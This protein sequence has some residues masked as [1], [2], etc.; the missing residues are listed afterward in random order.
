M[1]FHVFSL[2]DQST[3]TMVEHLKFVLN[4]AMS[5]AIHD[6]EILLNIYISCS[7]IRLRRLPNTTSV[8]A[9]VSQFND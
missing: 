5:E 9:I 8:E 4:V 1:S 6:N 2:S 7:H 3:F